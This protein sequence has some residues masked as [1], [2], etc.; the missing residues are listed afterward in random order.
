MRGDW[1]DKLHPVLSWSSGN[2]SGKQFYLEV[3][4]SNPGEYEVKR[5]K[6]YR[7]FSVIRCSVFLKKMCL[8]D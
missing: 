4:G 5:K 6:K 1:G 3:G 7:I 8:L 2:A